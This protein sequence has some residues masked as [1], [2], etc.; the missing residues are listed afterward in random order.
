M[1]SPP[2]EC[3]YL[4]EQPAS[5]EIRYY[6]KKNYD[7]FDVRIGYKKSYEEFLAGIKRILTESKRVLKTGKYCAFNINDFRKDGKFYAYHADIIRLGLE[8]GFKSPAFAVALVFIVIPAEE[9]PQRGN[10]C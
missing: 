3:L 8:V 9:F 2:P 10:E 4:Y 1:G 7:I 6:G 5:K